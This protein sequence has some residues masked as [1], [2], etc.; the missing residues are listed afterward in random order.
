MLFVKCVY[1]L[2]EKKENNIVHDEKGKV[3]VNPENI[4]T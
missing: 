1:S 4:K 2:V 3:V